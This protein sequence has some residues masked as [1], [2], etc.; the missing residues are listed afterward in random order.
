MVRKRLLAH[1]ARHERCRMIGATLDVAVRTNRDAQAAGHASRP[2]RPTAAELS[3]Q[4]AGGEKPVELRLTASLPF[5][6]SARALAVMTVSGMATSRTSTA[7]GLTARDVTSGAT[8]VVA[9]RALPTAL[10]AAAR[11]RTSTTTLAIRASQ[12]TAVMGYR[13]RTRR[14]AIAAG[15]SAR[16]RASPPEGALTTSTA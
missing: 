8:A 4:G 16:E 10:L 13:T 1:V 9:P 14:I 6:T 2:E 5:A 7:V 11:V 12:P 15:V 3:A